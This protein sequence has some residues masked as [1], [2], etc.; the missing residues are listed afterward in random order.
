MPFSDREQALRWVSEN[1]VSKDSRSCGGSAA[2]KLLIDG[3][4]ENDELTR[5]LI[6]AACRRLLAEGVKS[7]TAEVFAKCCNKVLHD[8]QSCYS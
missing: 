5:A 6:K 8:W 4:G 7:C 3:E 2:T 1:V